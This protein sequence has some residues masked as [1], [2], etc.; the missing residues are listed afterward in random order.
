LPPRAR[1]VLIFGVEDLSQRGRDEAALIAAAV[2]EHVADEVQGAPLRHAGQHAR[3]RGLVTVVIVGDRQLQAR[4]SALAQAAQ[5]LGP[6]RAGLDLADVRANHLPHTSLM[7]GV[8]DYQRLGHDPAPIA[9]L[10]LLGAQPQLGIGALQRPLAEELDLLIQRPADR[11][12]AVLGHPLD[13][14]LFHQPI[15]LTGAHAVDIRLQHDRDDRLLG[16]APRL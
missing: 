16:P 13:P 1:L 5:E 12:N 8:G 15:D 3:D 7:H 6:E 9:D 4:E 2:V 14:Q 11:S 10:D